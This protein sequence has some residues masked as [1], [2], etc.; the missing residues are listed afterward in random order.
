MDD[1]DDVPPDLGNGQSWSSQMIEKIKVLQ[2]VLP[3]YT[4]ESNKQMT[5]E[6]WYE[7]VFKVQQDHRGLSFEESKL[8]YLL[9]FGCHQSHH[10]LRDTKFVDHQ[11]QLLSL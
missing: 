1:F 7:E 9:K 10:H 4:L 8:E 6:N 5:K 11:F 3:D 2:P